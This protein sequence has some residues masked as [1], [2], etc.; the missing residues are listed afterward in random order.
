MTS[1]GEVVARLQQAIEAIER[2]AINADGVRNES[3]QSHGSFVEAGR[4]TA[5]PRM[6]AAITES[7]TASE[8]AGKAARLLS[9][10]ARHFTAYINI[11][12]PGAG[13]SRDAASNVMP[14]GERLVSEAADRE[15]RLA[16]FH[17]RAVQFLADREG[18]FKDVE[19]FSRDSVAA[20]RDRL[21]PGD[22]Q[23]S[24]GT[25]SQAPPAQPMASNSQHPATDI[26]LAAA[27]MTLAVRAGVEKVR[28]IRRRRRQGDDESKAD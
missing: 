12:A 8:K 3:E 10:A 9:E 7:R 25:P 17:R 20:F 2:A 13:P 16:R 15:S 27:S 22:A 23:A 1:V 21:R 18:D 6:R 26:L 4:G 24:V 19:Q 14:D 11:I 5:D 28:E